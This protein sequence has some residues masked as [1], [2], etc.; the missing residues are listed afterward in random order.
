MA[1]TDLR[2]AAD[3]CRIA[4][5]LHAVGGRQPECKSMSSSIYLDM[6]IYLCHSRTEGVEAES[7]QRQR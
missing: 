1:Q 3:Q 2:L 6:D 4:L 5:I 7:G